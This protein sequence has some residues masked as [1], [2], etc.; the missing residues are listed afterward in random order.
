MLP[1]HKSFV[2]ISVHRN[3]PMKVVFGTKR[4]RLANMPARTTV[5]CA[6]A[7]RKECRD[8]LVVPTCQMAGRDDCGTDTTERASSLQHPSKATTMRQKILTDPPF[9][10]RRNSVLRIRWP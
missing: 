7:K 9:P 4:W 3:Q 2:E 10:L 6:L 8:E 1:A 5:V